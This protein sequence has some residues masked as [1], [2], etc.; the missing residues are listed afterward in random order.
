MTAV[1]ATIL[2]CSGPV[3]DPEE[4]AFLRD[5]A[6]WGFILF[7]R[8][9]SEPEQLRRLTGALREAVGRDAPVLIDQEGGRVQRLAAPHWRRWPRPLDAVDD[10]ADMAARAMV[11]RYRL[12]ARDLA[13]VGIDVNCAPCCDIAGPGTHAFLAD[14]CL[15]RDAATVAR[16]ARAAA[17]GLLAGGVLPVIKHIPGHGRAGAD[18]HHDLPVVETPL[19]ELRAT[20]FAV[21]RA[22]A[23]LP[24]AMTAHV[25]YSALDPDRA[26]TLSPAAVAEIRGAM[27]FDGL[28]ITD[29]MSMRA[30]RGE[31]G[32]LTAEAMVAGCDI[33]LHCNG[34]RDEA[35]RVVAAAGPLAGAAAARAAAALARRT[36]PDGS[37]PDALDAEL[38]ALSAGRAAAR[39]A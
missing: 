22:L 23:D 39:D 10:A 26:A 21:F 36:G 3:L 15:G 18:S 25:L 16:N 9:V 17:Q 12:I 35:A 7:A 20:D 31:I 29:D 32:A 27:A 1:S 33:A 30:L 28:L 13:A 5:A 14:R 2:G 8:N 37:D 34:N 19:A 6:P 11:L 24:M 38:A 4:A